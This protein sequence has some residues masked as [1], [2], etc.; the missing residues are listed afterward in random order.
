MVQLTGS[1]PNAWPDPDTASFRDK[2]PAKLEIE[3][4]LEEEHGPRNKRSKF[5]TQ[6]NEWSTG[7]NEFPVP[8]SQYNL[9]DEP[10]P[11]GLRLKK[12]PSLLDLIQTRI[13]QD[14]HSSVTSA[15][16]ENLN[17]RD[18]KGVKGTI[19]SVTNDKMKASNFPALLL[20]IG[21][22]EYVSGYEGDLVGKCYYAKHKL[23]WEILEGG[24]KSKIEIQWSDI[25]ALKADFLDNGPGTLTVTLARPPLFFKETNP[26]PRKHTLWQASAD[27]TDGQA[28]IHRQHFLQCT[29]G[30]LNKHYDKLIQCDLHL[31]LVSRQPQMGLD[32]PYYEAHGSVL[33]DPVEFEALEVGHLETA[34]RSPIPSFKDVK[35]PSTAQ[36]CSFTSEEQNSAGLMSE[37]LSSQTP[38]PSS[39]MDL[40]AIEGNESSGGHGFQAQRSMSMS[41]LVNHIGHC[42][43]ERMTSGNLSSHFKEALESQDML[44]NIAEILLSD[45]QFHAITDEKKLMSRVNSLCYLLQEPTSTPNKQVGGESHSEGHDDGKRIQWNH[46]IESMHESIAGTDVG[47]R[48]AYSNSYKQTPPVM[49]RTDSFGDLLSSLPRIASLPKFLFDI[50]EDDESQAR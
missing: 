36:S 30:L 26:Q 29:Q 46:D 8:P 43:L 21:H 40:P 5:S 37:H 4:S 13:S 47:F 44:E 35:S 3:D 6:L 9:L 10:S 22:W 1:G 2:F 20:K 25:A 11:L 42:I 31:N 12:S 14:N 45:K 27:F 41:D 33:K 24:L 19:A 17:L 15:T 48:G 7:N 39:V 16:S 28:S 18:K 32:S 50:S 38:S 23:V 34:K 49:S